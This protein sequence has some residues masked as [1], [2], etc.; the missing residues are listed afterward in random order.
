MLNTQPVKMDFSPFLSAR[1]NGSTANKAGAL[2][3]ALGG[4][5]T[6]IDEHGAN[7]DEKEL[8]KFTNET[9]ESK[10]NSENFYSPLNAAK[11]KDL[12]N[13]NLK[14]SREA[15]LNAR[16]D[17]QYYQDVFT[18]E[19]V[20]DAQTMDKKTFDTKYANAGGFDASKVQNVWDYKDNKE[21]INKQR[22]R[23]DILNA[24]TDDDYAYNVN[25]RKL[26]DG[27]KKLLNDVMSG[28]IQTV[29]GLAH[30]ADAVDPQSYA[31][32]KKIIEDESNKK[33]INNITQKY[34]SFAEFK[35][36]DE[37][38]TTPY[39]VK[40]TVAKSKVWGES[41]KDLSLTD[42]IKLKEINNRKT[43]L[44]NIQEQYKA[45][46]GKNMS[47]TDQS[48]YLYK[49][50]L[51]ELLKEQKPVELK[52]LKVDEAKDLDGLIKYRETL[53][54]LDKNYDSSYVGGLDSSLNTITPN[55]MLTDG[56]RK[57]NTTMNDVLLGKTSALAGTL[58]DKDMALLSAS[59]ISETLGEKDF[60]EAV[61]NQR[62]KVNQL[63]KERYNLLS[64][65]YEMPEHYSFA[66]D[67]PSTIEKD[68][69]S[70][71]V[72]GGNTK[73][74]EPT[75]IGTGKKPDGTTVKT[76]SDGTTKFYN[77]V[78][79]IVYETKN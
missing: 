24:R 22:D 61:A 60:K 11:A 31:Q 64:S 57:F 47:I 32:A 58:S 46:Y 26:Q 79:Q 50:E 73:A 63:I 67:L 29:D 52:P 62:A 41:A 45:K 6:M 68:K 42:E 43:D 38:K 12:V 27:G 72:I 69:K 51:P 18:Q 4:I 9:D 53:S 40:D 44:P 21:Y 7:S 13:M 56:H 15:E 17:A 65:Q 75:V 8:A 49:G 76:F 54:E 70:V 16:T 25:T 1:Q 55:W 78:G 71:K 19:A 10:I 34:T 66:K 28:T 20:S 5:A 39:I 33:S 35:N 36:S 23:Q 14:K 74:E 3:K 2:A 48:N 37:W 77:K 59:G 30:Y